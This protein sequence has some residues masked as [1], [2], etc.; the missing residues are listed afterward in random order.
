M[1]IADRVVELVVDRMD[2]WQNAMSGLGTLRDKQTSMAAV[3]TTQLPDN[4]LEAMYN[5]DDLVARIVDQLP[6]DAVRAGF[7]VKLREEDSDTATTTSRAIVTAVK[8]LEG[9]PKLSQAWIWARLYGGGAVVMGAD[10]G[11]E[12]DK[13][14][15]LERVKQL[16]FLNVLRRTQL[17]IDTYYDDVQAPK[18]GEPATFKL[19]QISSTNSANTQQGERR[20]NTSGEL[21][22][23]ESRLLMFK[24]VQAARQEQING[25]MWPDSMLQRLKPVMQASNSSWL[26]VSH[27]MTDASQGV[28]KL[29]NLMQMLSTSGE[30]LLRK[31]MQMME[32]ARSVCRSILIDADKESFERVATSFTGLPEVLDRQMM[33]VSAAGTMPTTILFQRSPAG[34]NATGESDT[35]G[36]Y[37]QV[38]AERLQHLQPKLEQLV[39]VLMATSDGPTQGKVLDFEITWPPLWQPSDKEKADTFKAMS[40][41]LV[42]LCTGQVVLPEEAALK[43]AHEGYF[44]ELDVDAREQALDVLRERI[45]NPPDEPDPNEPDP[46]APKPGSKPAGAQP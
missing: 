10:D 31:R 13:P 34:M 25:S 18:Y 21:V 36:W 29:A 23:H 7:G 12:L 1:T 2:A 4:E 22:I 14:L 24:G 19:L 38:A 16:R 40:D 35:R 45:A 3:A 30:M 8:D 5:D 28:L 41:A 17:Q 44:A 42:A 37:D 20:R 6:R 26:S 33:R 27:L 43:L 9:L 46:N 39:R 11:Q 15:A 32:M